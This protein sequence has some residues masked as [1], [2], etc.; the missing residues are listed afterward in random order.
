MVVFA[1]FEQ[2]FKGIYVMNHARIKILTTGLRMS[3][4][5]NTAIIDIHPMVDINLYNKISL[6]LIMLR[7]ENIQRLSSQKDVLVIK[8]SYYSFENNTS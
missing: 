2:K 4:G 5:T 7:A 6:F 8:Y 3:S 1:D